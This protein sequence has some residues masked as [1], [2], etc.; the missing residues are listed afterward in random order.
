MLNEE[1]MDKQQIVNIL[2]KKLEKDY[3]YESGFILGSMCTEPLEI[4]K[5]VYIDYISK[6][7]GDPGLFQG[8][9]DL[10]DELVAD[11]GK[12]FRGNNIMG[13]FT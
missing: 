8:T 5:E 3:S 13:S 1:G 10:E 12:L 6:N 2:N 4:G 7:L 9:A 11:I